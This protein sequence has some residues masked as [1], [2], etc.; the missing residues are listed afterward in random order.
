MKDHIMPADSSSITRRRLLGGAVA[1]GIPL[2]LAACGGTNS[3]TS[4][5]NS[6]TSGPVTRGGNLRVGV[7]G[8][9]AAE[10]LNPLKAAVQ[11]D[12]ARSLQVYES[13]VKLG[14]NGGVENVLAEEITANADST[15]WT[16]RLLP[17]ILWHNGKTLSADDVIYT[18]KYS[19]NPKSQSFASSNFVGLNPNQIKKVDDLTIR[20]KLESPNSLFPEQ[21]TSY[22]SIIPAGT[23]SFEPPIGTGPFKFVSWTRGERAKYTRFS[24]YRVHNGPYLDSVEIISL[25]S[26]EARNNALIAGQVDLIAE[27]PIVN[28]QTIKSN[29]NLQLLESPGGFWGGMYMETSGSVPF[30]SNKVREALKLLIDRKQVV[31]NALDGHGRIGNDIPTITDPTYPSGLEQREFDPEKAKSLLKEAG[32]EGLDVSLA[33]AEV[34]T[35]I[36]ATTTLFAADAQAGGVTINLDKKPAG[37]YF[38]TTWTKVPFGVTYFGPRTAYGFTNETLLADAAQP[39]TKWKNPAFFKLTEEIKKEGNEKL[40]NEMLTQMQE[41]VWSEGGY[42]IPSFPNFIAG[43]AKKVQSVPTSPISFF[44]N[45]DFV[46]VSIKA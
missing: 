20:L 42:I 15:E 14:P 5:G 27:V 32:K 24:D 29:P 38:D 36:F 18:I 12:A 21:L 31:E 37:T 34:Y 26:P 45:W 7:S 41:I 39:E 46:N 6:T 17:E 3:L 22:G 8:G 28:V 40:R 9:G 44:N 2:A 19:L 30:A 16:I 10:T 23:T 13:L 4:A 35:G 11:S 43:A 1:A 25:E 33:T